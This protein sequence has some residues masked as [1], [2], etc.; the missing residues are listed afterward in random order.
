MAVATHARLVGLD[1]GGTAVKAGCITASGE[2][3]E[4][5]SAAPPFEHGPDAV[6]DLLA[7]IARDLGVREGLGIGVPGLLDRGR[8]IVLESPNL[9]GFRGVDVRGGLARRLGLELARVCVEN[10]ANAAA[11]GE[12]WLGAARNEPDVLLL[13]LGTGI[14][15]GLILGGRLVVGSG[16]GGEPGH[17]VIE[18]D[19]P[20]CACGARGCAETLASAAAAR[21]RA[22]QAGL[23]P[24]APGD[25]ERL[26]A[27]AREGLPAESQLLSEVGRDL[28]HLLGVVVSLL[29]LR[30]YVFGGG[31][32]AALDTLES[33]IRAG[34]AERSYGDRAGKIR[35]LRA[36][37]GPS[38]GWIGAA[39]TLAPA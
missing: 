18:P 27:R 5:K 28:G 37:L 39:R 3:L 22:L 9:P 10:D 4:E 21:R 35:L 1:L 13:T 16:F 7:E 30:F 11:I 24:E 20:R 32:S 31:F 33:G 12:Q 2:V 19:G 26:A 6:L 23:P 29:D 14:G 8:G 38:A 17:V 25:L 34:I 36:A 15:G